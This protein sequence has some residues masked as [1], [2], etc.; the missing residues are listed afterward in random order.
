VL[1]GIVLLA[2]V[3]LGCIYRGHVL[4]A[5]DFIAEATGGRTTAALAVLGGLLVV[6]WLFFWLLLPILVWFGLRDLRHRTAE[7]DESLRVCLR[8]LA[9]LAEERELPETT[10][11]ADPPRDRGAV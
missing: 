9:Q 6:L 11:A 4:S 10:R 1:T 3:V 7:L 8:H 2:L 5:L